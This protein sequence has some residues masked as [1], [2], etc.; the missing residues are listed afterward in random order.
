MRIMSST[1]DQVGNKEIGEKLD[2]IIALLTPPA[3][4]TPKGFSQEFIAFLKQYKILGLAVA[5]VFAI[6]LGELILALVDDF[7][8]PIIGL[9]LGVTGGGHI[10][11]YYY[12]IFG[13]GP[14]LIA[15]ITFLFVALIIFGIVKIA[16]KYNIQ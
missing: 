14:F 9:A 5:F 6:Y 8:V 10:Q 3:Q 1:S 16:G 4:P 11:T 7:I 13:I 12:W 15:V 2:K